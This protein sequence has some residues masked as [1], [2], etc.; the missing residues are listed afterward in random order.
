MSF[1]SQ[2]DALHEQAAV[3]T[4]LS[5]FD[6][7][8]Y[9]DGMRF[10]LDDY[11]KHNC[12]N[13]KGAQSTATGCVLAVVGRLFDRRVIAI[14]VGYCTVIPVPERRSLHPELPHFR[15]SRLRVKGNYSSASRR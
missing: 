4:W 3:I 15:K 6:R 10:L 1:L 14:D 9:V 8:D 5:D 12:F 13:P 11:D 2:F 7:Y